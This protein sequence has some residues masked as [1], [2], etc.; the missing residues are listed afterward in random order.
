MQQRL[1]VSVAEAAASLS[2]AARTIR[3]WVACGRIRCVRLGRRVV[4]P[5]SELQRLV[6]LPETHPHERDGP[7]PRTPIEQPDEQNEKA[8]GQASL[9]G[10][11]KLR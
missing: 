10:E 7:P 11:P 8:R 4:I 1:A 2:I 5:V 3:A 6:A 9:R